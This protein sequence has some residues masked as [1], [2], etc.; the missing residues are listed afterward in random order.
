M[1]NDYIKSETNKNMLSFY[2]EN[3]SPIY[4]KVEKL[5]TVSIP[6]ENEAKVRE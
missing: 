3:E 6:K 4:R 2:N 5:R 1:H